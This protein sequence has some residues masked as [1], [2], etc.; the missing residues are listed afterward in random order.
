MQDIGKLFLFLGFI[1]LL[2]S[3]I[4]NIMP[5][6]PRV[7]GDIYIDRPSLKIHIPFTSAIVISVILAL[8]FN[9]FRK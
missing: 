2:L 1:F 9:F 6:L 7:P 3:L 5:N 8:I 4:F